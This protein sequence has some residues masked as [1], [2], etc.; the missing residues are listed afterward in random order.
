MIS[1]RQQLC[2][3]FHSRPR[4]AFESVEPWNSASKWNW[5]C[6]SLMLS[7]RLRL[8]NLG[9]CR[10]V[11]QWARAAEALIPCQIMKLYVA[12]ANL[13]KT[14]E[15][16]SYLYRWSRPD[17]NKNMHISYIH[18]IIQDFSILGFDGDCV[19]STLGKFWQDKLYKQIGHCHGRFAQQHLNGWEVTTTLIPSLLDL[20]SLS[21]S[22]DLVCGPHCVMSTLACSNWWTGHQ[23]YTRNAMRTWSRHGSDG[24]P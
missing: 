15:T 5:N 13:T 14:K 22:D 11:S 8:W 20:Q 17:I 10:V 1:S 12:A 24:Q 19:S 3:V 4:A 23:K 6:E 21:S 7:A 18:Y 2:R 9:S 16:R